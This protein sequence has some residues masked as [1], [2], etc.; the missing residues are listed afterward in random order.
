M[1]TIYRM[2]MGRTYFA[3]GKENFHV[4]R[5]TV[6]FIMKQFFRFYTAGQVLRTKP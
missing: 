2:L 6:V 5:E 3:K 4:N 1:A